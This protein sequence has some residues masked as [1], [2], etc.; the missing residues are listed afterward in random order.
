[1]K[2][3]RKGHMTEEWAQSQESAREPQVED[4]PL[5]KKRTPERSFG[6]YEHLLHLYDEDDAERKEQHCS[7]GVPE[8]ELESI[9]GRLQHRSCHDRYENGTRLP[10]S[11]PHGDI[12]ENILVVPVGA[13]GPAAKAAHSIAKVVQQFGRHSEASF[14]PGN[15]APPGSAYLCIMGDRAV[16]YLRTSI[17]VYWNR[18]EPRHVV[19]DKHE[20]VRPMVILG[21]VAERWRGKPII[22][23][24]MRRFADDCG[25][26]PREMVFQPPFS[27]EGLALALHYQRHSGVLVHS[28]RLIGRGSELA[29]NHRAQAK[30]YMSVDDL[31]KD[32]M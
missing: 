7:C 31:P 28:G 10:E 25:V 29:A 24:M 21:F 13:R 12:H 19:S 1:M 6:G 8:R 4:A 23:Q 22:Y 30:K 14:R 26:S 9:H 5:K 15:L 16:G 11:F 27:P 32:D 18:L 17:A 3:H 20:E 2:R